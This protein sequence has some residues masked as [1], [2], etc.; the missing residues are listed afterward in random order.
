MCVHVSS[1]LRFL[2]VPFTV[3]SLSLALLERR[4]HSRP[5]DFSGPVNPNQDARGKE[6]TV[7]AVFIN[8]RHTS[9]SV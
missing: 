8:H 2:R 7:D 6:E 5:S 9:V 3:G 1:S 4:R